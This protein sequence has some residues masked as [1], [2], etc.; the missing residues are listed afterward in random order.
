MP[1]GR[2]G[3]RA[4]ELGCVK[5]LVGLRNGD[6]VAGERAWVGEQTDEVRG[7]LKV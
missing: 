2:G 3:G 6:S 7:G 5:V 4:E 1:K